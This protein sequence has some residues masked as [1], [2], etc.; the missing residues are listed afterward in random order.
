MQ[1]QMA[2]EEIPH[3]TITRRIR[4]FELVMQLD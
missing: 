3:F 4:K 2:A 1:N